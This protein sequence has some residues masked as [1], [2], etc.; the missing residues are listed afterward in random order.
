MAGQ[1]VFIRELLTVFSGNELSIGLV[2]C[3]WLLAGAAGAFLFPVLSPRA[4]GE[5]VFPSLLAFAGLYMP[6]AVIATGFIRPWFGLVPGEIAPVAPLILSTF[7]LVLPLCACLGFMFGLAC[8]KTEGNA[9]KVYAL[10]SAGSLLGGAAASAVFTRFF[11]SLEISGIL[12]GIACACAAWALGKKS[13]RPAVMFALCAVLSFAALMSGFWQRLESASIARRWPGY[14]VRFNGSSIYGTVTVLQRGPQFSF[15]DNGVLLASAPDP[16]AAEEAVHFA[17]LQHPHPGSVLLIGGGNAG[18]LPEILK[19]NVKTVDY[20]ELDPLL[21][22]AGRSTLPREL[23][24]APGDPRVTISTTDARAFVAS[25]ASRYDCVIVCLG[26]PVTAMVNRFYTREFFRA[27]GA[28]MKDGGIL[29][30]GLPASESF[31]NKQNRDFIQSVYIALRSSF[32]A[33]QAIPGE[34]AWFLAAKSAPALSGDYRLLVKRQEERGIDIKYVREYY[35]FSRMASDKLAWFSRQLSGNGV[36]ENRDFRPSAYY[37]CLAS[38]FSRFRNPVF[39][40]TLE[41][42]KEHPFASL[43]LIF[44]SVLWPVVLFR[45]DSGARGIALAAVSVNGFS[46]MASQVTVLFGFQVLYGYLFYQLALLFTCFMA[47]ASVGA[48]WLTRQMPLRRQPVLFAGAAVFY[49]LLPAIFF[50]L[51]VLKSPVSRWNGSNLIFPS[52]SLFCGLI[53]GAQFVVA[54]RMFGR[55]GGNGPAVVYGFDLFGSCLGA[56]FSALFLIPVLGVAAACFFMCLLNLA[57]ALVSYISAPWE[58][59][60]SR[61]EA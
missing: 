59:S 34:T 25:T 40:S 30:F 47:G 20:V 1:V 10:E 42:G 39:V 55:G 54:N 28:V 61:T 9:G 57:V 45:K 5:A 46:A 43:A 33:T 23:N 58:R 27:A 49:A 21:V 36:S 15:L 51:S 32:T 44:C 50:L 18:L 19:H 4:R 26:P 37:Y 22:K 12:A 3:C 7:L 60:S 8:A 29:C 17:L 38:W 35:L 24:A 14:A 13:L 31:L 11:S 56:L 52:L 2:L 48:L 41:K 6:V 16:Q 53:A